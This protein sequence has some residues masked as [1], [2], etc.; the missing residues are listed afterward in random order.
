MRDGGRIIELV[1]RVSIRKLAQPDELEDPLPPVQRQLGW[2]AGDEQ[3]PE[4]AFTKQVIELVR[5]LVN[6]EQNEYPEL[7]RDKVMPVEGRSHVRQECP[8][9]MVFD[10]PEADPVF[11]QTRDE[12]DGPIEKRFE[13]DRPNQRRAIEAADRSRSVGD[14]H[15]FSDDERPAGNQHEAA[16]CCT[17][18]GNEQVCRQQDQVE[19]DEKE[20][21]RRQHFAQL[22]QHESSDPACDSGGCMSCGDGDLEVGGISVRNRCASHF[23]LLRAGPICD[24]TKQPADLNLNLDDFANFMKHANR[25][26]LPKPSNKAMKWVRCATAARHGSMSEGCNPSHGSRKHL[27]RLNRGLLDTSRCER[28]LSLDDLPVVPR[29]GPDRQSWNARCRG[30]D[31]RDTSEPW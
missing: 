4:L 6:Q 13:Q 24:Q 7:D 27:L 17:I 16:E 11:K 10:K 29:L 31:D 28:D 18:I 30:S 9:R 8:K 19:A 1:D 21:R 23:A 2:P 20:D 15:C 22:A 5:Y 14:K 12:H 3:V 25:N 26:A